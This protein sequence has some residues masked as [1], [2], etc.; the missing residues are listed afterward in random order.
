MLLSKR[1][2]FLSALL[3]LVTLSGCS[4]FLG[5]NRHLS[6]SYV[7]SPT[8][9]CI[10]RALTSVDG[11]ELQDQHENKGTARG[12]KGDYR[13]K[14]NRYSYL[15][16]DVTVNLTVSTYSDSKEYRFKQTYHRSGAD[17]QRDVDF[18][19]PVMIEVEGRIAE[20]C[21]I[22][23]FQEKIKESCSEVKCISLSPER[24][25]KPYNN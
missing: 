22:P 21:G 6:L 18:I 8:A 16:R 20:E 12:S 13:W 4:K 1:L 2:C 10:A 9:G 3:L 7:P 11:V 23:D 24:F 17:Y 19:R 15:A 14:E 25:V 5:V